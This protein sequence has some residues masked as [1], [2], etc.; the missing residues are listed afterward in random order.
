[1]MRFSRVLTPAERLALRNRIIALGETV[2]P[3]LIRDVKLVGGVKAFRE[4]AGR[5]WSLVVGG[6]LRSEMAGE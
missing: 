5:I 2:E 4:F 1:M 3:G 6:H